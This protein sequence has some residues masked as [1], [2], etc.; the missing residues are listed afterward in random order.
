MQETVAV[1]SS[2]DAGDEAVGEDEAGASVDSASCTLL[3]LLKAHEETMGWIATGSTQFAAGSWRGLADV[4]LKFAQELTRRDAASGEPTVLKRN[5]IANVEAKDH[6]ILAFMYLHASTPEVHAPALL[7]TLF[8]SVPPPPLPCVQLSLCIVCVH[9]LHL[10][11]L[12]WLVRTHSL[13]GC[14]SSSR[15]TR[16]PRIP[17]ALWQPPWSM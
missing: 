11:W 3:T 14:L 6:R 7:W 4:H 16:K 2:L 1:Q 8:F 9:R 13:V 12:S 5:M 10:P 17:S 15:R